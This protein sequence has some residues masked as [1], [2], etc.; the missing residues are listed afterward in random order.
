MVP[1]CFKTQEICKETVREESYALKF[2]PDHRKT[3][4]KCDT[5][6]RINPAAFFLFLTVLKL[7]RCVLKVLRYTHGSWEMTLI[8]LKYKKCATRQWSAA[9]MR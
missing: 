3:L 9:H 1:D 7:K 5:A 6:V 2:V 4:D 8:I